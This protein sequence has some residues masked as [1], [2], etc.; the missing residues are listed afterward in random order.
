LLS[1]CGNILADF[2]LERDIPSAL[3]EGYVITLKLPVYPFGA[4]LCK[5]ILIMRRFY[6]FAFQ[7]FNERHAGFETGN[8]PSAL[9]FARRPPIYLAKPKMMAILAVFIFFIKHLVHGIN[10]LTPT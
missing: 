1:A 8:S 3:A 10:F 7:I 5:Q 4:Y 6:L 9:T 2:K